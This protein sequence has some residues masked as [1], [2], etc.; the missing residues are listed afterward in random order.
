MKKEFIE[1][2][3]K[4]EARIVVIGLGR[5]GL[6]TAAA[7]ADAGYCVIGVDVRGDLIEA[8]SAANFHTNEPGLKELIKRVVVSGRLKTST[9]A[10]EAVKESDVAIICVQTPLNK[11]RKPNLT[12]LRK[13]CKA[14]AQGL[15]R[16]KLVIVESTVPP[17]TMR[18]MVARMLEMG[19]HL[20][21]SVDF[22]LAYCPERI[23]PGKILQ[24]LSENSRLA[25][26]FD[27][28]S[29]TV[30]SEL[31][32]TV[33]KGEVL[34]TDVG[35]AEVAKLAENAFRDVN[36]AFANEL[37][38]IC[39]LAKV[40]VMEVI[41]L[42]NTH[43]RVMVHKPGCGVG[44]PCLTKDPYLLLHV[45]EKSPLDSKVILA[46]RKLNDDMPKHAVD[47]VVQGLREARKKVEGSKIVVFGVAYKGETDDAS[48]SPSEKIIRILK[49]MKA[50]V[51]VYDPFCAESFGAKKA[52][53]ILRA[54]TNADCLLIATDHKKFE[55][56][57]FNKIKMLMRHPPIIVDGKRMMNPIR[58]KKE[59]FH[60]Y[61]TGYSR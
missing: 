42:A 12:Y 8:I 46:S 3:R 39:E 60:Y 38:L 11:S 54:V 52:K 40:D 47:L 48:N 26:C 59:G 51:W 53:D 28:D 32:R 56:L 15:S 27:E 6:P 19:S 22:W 1:K 37:A 29:A 10:V 16:G 36:I 21:C 31:L 44:G 43:S 57:D 14:V 55:E 20:K 24:E 33:T 58:M 41:R 18:N 4:R 23:T 49:K 25:G 50:D 34:V 13:P 61:G 5:V 9:N 35:S 7:F 45:L 17:R 30:A 2:L